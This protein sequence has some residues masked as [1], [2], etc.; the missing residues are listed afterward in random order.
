MKLLFDENNL[1]A[2]ITQLPDGSFR[3]DIPEIDG[4]SAEGSSEEE[5]EE[6]LME[7]LRVL[8][9]MAKNKRQS[10]R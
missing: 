1:T 8:K 9:L 5:A 2:I 6:I 4:M 7:K 3:A 10:R